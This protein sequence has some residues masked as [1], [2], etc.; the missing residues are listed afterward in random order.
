MKDES[1]VIDDVKG[2]EVTVVIEEKDKP[3]D[4]LVNE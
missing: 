2:V 3:E 4:T 1:P